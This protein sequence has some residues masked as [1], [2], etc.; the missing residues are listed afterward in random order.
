M[1]DDSKDDLIG[2]VLGGYRLVEKIGQG[3]MGAVY[4]GYDESLDRHVAV[5]IL[6]GALAN[7]QTYVARFAREAKSVAK[8]HH[9]NL[10]HIYAVGEERG[11]HYFAM[12]FIEGIPLSEKIAA[13]GGG[14]ELI[15]AIRII[16][17]TMSALEKVHSLDIVHRDIKS[18][19]IMLTHDGR[20]ILMD[21]GLAKGGEGLEGVT[22]A[23]IV[24]GTPEYMPPEQALG[25]AVTKQG[26]IYSVGV[27]LFEMLTGRLPFKGKSAIAVIRQHAEAEPPKPTSIRSGIPAALE[28]VVLRA[29]A[30]PLDVRYA[31]L[32]AMAV[33]LLKVGRT[34]ELVDLAGTAAKTLE[35]SGMAKAPAAPA[36]SGATAPTIVEPASQPTIAASQPGGAPTAEAPPLRGPSVAE[37]GAQAEAVPEEPS[38][39]RTAA[40]IA[41]AVVAALAIFLLSLHLA[42][43]KPPAPAPEGPKAKVELRGD[44]EAIFGRVESISKTEK[45]WIAVIVGEDGERK[46]IEV[47]DLREL[48][49]TVVSDESGERDDDEEREKDTDE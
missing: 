44:D 6:P 46:E 20:A 42:T 26:D 30:K 40:V 14:L 17:Q 1:P 24:L 7:D 36:D 41:V 47:D 23:G 3:G 19:N 37:Q 5:K 10:I 18:S 11:Y 4:K 33:E 45:G 29:M 13:S 22:A 43:R 27:L 38:S 35:M 34:R 25:E 9:P 49:F 21:F 12:E 16:G 32:S 28:G 2:A 31:T 15:D 8:L 39:W 48:D